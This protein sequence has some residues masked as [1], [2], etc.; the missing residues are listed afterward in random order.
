MALASGHF[1]IHNDLLTGKRELN[2]RFRDRSRLKAGELMTTATC[3]PRLIHRLRAGWA[4]QFR[5]FPDG[6]RAI[7][8]VYLPG[9]VIGLDSA[10]QTRPVQNVL[11]L[12]SII[13]DAIDAETGLSE[14]MAHMPTALYIAWLL[15][16]RQRRSD[17]LFSAISCLDARG[18]VAMMVLDLYKRLTS[19]RLIASTTYNLPLTQSQIGGYLGLTVVHVNRVLRVLRDELIVN[20]EKHCVTILNFDQLT[21]LAQGGEISRPSRSISER[22]QHPAL[23]IG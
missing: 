15:S 4:C 14:M 6:H 13:A 9:D 16:Q 17:R 20:V 5:D 21:K 22:P 19:R 1:E 18:R 2:S 12:T 8:D 10:L 3:S 7:V 23:M 11:T